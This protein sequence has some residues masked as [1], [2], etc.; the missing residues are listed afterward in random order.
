MCVKGKTQGL[1]SA[2]CGTFDSI[3]NFVRVTE[4]KKSDPVL[5]EEINNKFC[6]ILVCSAMLYG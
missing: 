1:I 6:M 4:I 3:G 5:F 2:W